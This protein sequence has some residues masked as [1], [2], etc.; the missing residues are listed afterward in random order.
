VPPRAVRVGTAPSMDDFPPARAQ[1]RVGL[2]A[3]RQRREKGTDGPAPPNR[4]RLGS[5][6]SRASN[7]ACHLDGRDAAPRIDHDTDS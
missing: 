4:G 5:L 3:E 6:V 2:D 7:H 1:R